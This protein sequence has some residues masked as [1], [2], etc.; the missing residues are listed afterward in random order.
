LGQE[1]ERVRRK[2]WE[3]A[4]EFGKE[5]DGKGRLDGAEAIGI[6]ELLGST[7]KADGRGRALLQS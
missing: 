3:E 4:I 7:G 5:D 6:W 1:I 2:A